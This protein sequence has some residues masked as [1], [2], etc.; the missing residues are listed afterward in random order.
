M[1]VR[2]SDG[3]VLGAASLAELEKRLGIPAFVILPRPDL[4]RA[5]TQ[6][7]NGSRTHCRARCVGVEESDG[8]VIARFA[9]GQQAE[10][11]LLIGADGLHSVVRSHLH[12]NEKPRYA[13]YTCWRGLAACEAKMLPLTTGFEAWGCGMRFS[14]YHCG[15]ESH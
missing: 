2:A 10:A 3:R 1:E 6:L 12:G 4:L 15:P 9:D 5:L 11:E 14:L 8:G 13:G 7:V